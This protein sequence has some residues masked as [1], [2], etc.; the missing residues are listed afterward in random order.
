MKINFAPFSVADVINFVTDPHLTFTFSQEGEDLLLE[1][2]FQEKGGAPGFYVDVGAHHPKRFSNTYTFHMRGWTGI[3]ID[4]T[5]GS[6]AAFQEQRPNDINLELGVGAE[7]GELTFFLFNEPA[8]NTFDAQ[9]AAFL[10]STTS[11]RVAGRHLVP[12]RRL[13]TVLSQ[14]CAG[15]T[16]DFLSIDTEGFDLA[17]VR[18]NDWERFRP[19]IVLLED[20]AT[21]LLALAE[22]EL[23]QFMLS[24]DYKPIVKLPRSVIYQDRRV[25]D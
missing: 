18:S 17:V 11:F 6:M 12:V 24:A 3:N 4:A 22:T 9:R 8:L 23:C 2:M 21:D 20:L 1:E 15:K 19:R 14:H 16:I 5:P 13:E 25:A 7:E 10:E